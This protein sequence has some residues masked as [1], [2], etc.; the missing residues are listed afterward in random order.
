M[1]I[2]VMAVVGVAPCQC[3]SP[4]GN[5]TTSPGLISSIGPPSRCAQPQPA[6]TISVCPSGWVCHAVRAPGSKVTHAPPARAGSWAANSGSRRT[7]PVKY[8]GDTCCD[9][10]EPLRRMSI[11][12]SPYCDTIQPGATEPPDC[13]SEQGL[14]DTAAFDERTLVSGINL[15]F[16]VFHCC[17][18]LYAC[19]NNG[20]LLDI[21]QLVSCH[22]GEILNCPNVVFHLSLCASAAN[23]DM[24][25]GLAQRIPEA[26]SWV[27]RP[28]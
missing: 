27:Q 19:T 8:S 22:L 24:D 1:A 5:Q 7:L 15:L 14:G 12:R 3:F 28:E 21:G 13:T 25:T 10:R 2:W 9:G 26:F 20:S 17:S 6:V 23:G 18:A 4:G 11:D 16:P